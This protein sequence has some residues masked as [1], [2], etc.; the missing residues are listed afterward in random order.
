[1]GSNV[2]ACGL[3][4]FSRLKDQQQKKLFRQPKRSISVGK[5]ASALELIGISGAQSCHIVMIFIVGKAAGY[6]RDSVSRT[7]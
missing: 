4:A 7:I 6:T 3:G 5:S 2:S 1:M